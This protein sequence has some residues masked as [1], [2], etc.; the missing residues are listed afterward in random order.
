MSSA[1]GVFVEIG[2]SGVEGYHHLNAASRKLDE[3]MERMPCIRSE[4][5]TIAEHVAMAGVSISCVAK[6]HCPGEPPAHG[7]D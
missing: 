2:F 6:H 3:L 1:G 7:N 5:E 4:L